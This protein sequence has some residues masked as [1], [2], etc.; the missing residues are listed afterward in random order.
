MLTI[1]PIPAFTD[2]YIWMI[3]DDHSKN[4]M[5]VDPGDAAPVLDFL[6]CNHLSLKAILI[7]HK[8]YDHSGGVGELLSYFPGT[9]VYVNQKENIAQTT[10]FT[11]ENEIL[12]I[13]KI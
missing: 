7:T 8:H 1:Y 5:V 12:N 3:V 11:V 10:H 4:A 9:P 6:R 13:P 2:N